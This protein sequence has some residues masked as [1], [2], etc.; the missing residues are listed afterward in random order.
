MQGHTGYKKTADRH[1][2][3][4]VKV[5]FLFGLDSLGYNV[6]LLTEIP[7]SLLR[8]T[9]NKCG[10]R[11]GGDLNFSSCFGTYESWWYGPGGELERSDEKRADQG[12]DSLIKINNTFTFSADLCKHTA[13][14]HT[15]T[16]TCVNIFLFR[17]LKAEQTW[18]GVVSTH[19]TCQSISASPPLEH[20]TPQSQFS[21]PGW[22][23]WLC[24]AGW[25]QRAARRKT[26]QSIN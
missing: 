7:V 15:N 24:Q 22:H 21:S 2:I 10:G 20:Q 11:I 13:L 14:I 23:C 9:C 3:F 18:W 25:L 16:P 1:F 5:L 19:R 4:H 6:L 8:I 17:L 12:F 26:T